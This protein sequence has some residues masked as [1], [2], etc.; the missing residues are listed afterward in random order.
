[1]KS[2]TQRNSITSS[3]SWWKWT[4][5]GTTRRTALTLDLIQSTV[6]LQIRSITWDSIIKSLILREGLWDNHLSNSKL[7]IHWIIQCYRLGLWNQECFWI[8]LIAY[9]HMWL[10]LEHPITPS[11]HPRELLSQ[12]HELSTFSRGI[13]FQMR[14]YRIGSSNYVF[15]GGYCNGSPNHPLVANQNINRPS[16]ER[17]PV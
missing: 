8:G 17:N 4:M 1:M 9:L 3:T 2:P 14:P 16:K 11:A 15:G 6:D 13:I 7:V 12:F 5:R 10:N